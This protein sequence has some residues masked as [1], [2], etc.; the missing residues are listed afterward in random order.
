M[1][2]YFLATIT[3][4]AF[5]YYS[6]YQRAFGTQ[7][8][9][10]VA[11]PN[12]SGNIPSPTVTPTVTPTSTPLPS[13]S[14]TTNVPTAIPDTPTPTSKPNSLYKDGTFTGDPADAFYGTIQV[15]AVISGGK[16]TD[17]KFLQAPSDRSTSIYINSQADPMLTQEAITAQSAQVDIISGATASSQAF[18]QSLQS[19]LDKAKN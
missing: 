5:I 10:I 16:I 15:Q 11:P 18:V 7:A 4:I 9:P 8:P 19:A 6:L 2:K 12:S 17:V 1:K 3:I 13:N 14:S